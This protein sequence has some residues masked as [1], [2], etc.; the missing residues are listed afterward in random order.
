MGDITLKG[1]QGALYTSKSRGNIIRLSN[2]DTKMVT[3]EEATKKLHNQGEL[4]RMTTR[5]LKGRN[6]KVFAT[7]AGK[8]TTCPGI[9]GPRKSNVTSSN[10]KMEDEWDAKTISVIGEDEVALMEMME[11][12][13]DYENNWIIDSGC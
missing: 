12:H 1:E 3:K 6:L 9:V 2:V 8:M 7:T 5:A 4:R 11:E 10:L 13:I